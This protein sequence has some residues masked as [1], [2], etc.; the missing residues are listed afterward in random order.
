LIG[1]TAVLGLLVLGG[2]AVAAAGGRGPTL[3][4]DPCVDVDE[5]TVRQVMDLEIVAGRA[6]DPGPS[7]TT[8]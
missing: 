3:T 1:I 6:D 2:D 8:W 7:T 5:A 4:I